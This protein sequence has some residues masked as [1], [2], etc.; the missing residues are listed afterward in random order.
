MATGL[1]KDPA[2][3]YATAGRLAEAAR[4]VLRGEPARGPRPATPTD[5]ADQAGPRPGRPR[6]RAAAR[7]PGPPRTVRPPDPSPAARPGRVIRPDP[8]GRASRRPAPGACRS[9]APRWPPPHWSPARSSGCTRPVRPG[10]RHGRRLAVRCGTSP[11]TCN[12]ADPDELR[13]GGEVTMAVDADVT[14]WNVAA[15]AGLAR[16]DP[17]GDGQRAA[18]HLQLAPD[19]TAHAQHRPADRRRADR[20]DHRRLHDQTGAP[21]G[22]TAPRSASTTSS[23][24]GGCATG[25]TARAASAI[26][27]ATTGSPRSPARPTAGRRQHGDRHVL[28]APTRTGATLFAST[29]PLY[30]AHLAARQ[31]DLRTPTGSAGRLRLVRRHRARLLGRPAGRA[32]LAAGPS[33]GAGPQPA[34]YG[35]PARLD[36]V[37]LQVTAGPGGP[38]AA[39]CATG[40]C[41]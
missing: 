5:R 36:R 20:S 3:R 16:P 15:P 2:E 37:V 4:S 27:P 10:L 40:G 8:I 34:W 17:V 39:R 28:H 23:S 6:P 33:A 26:R 9:A 22:T 35:R 1:A 13:A 21:A 12:G 11:L 29:S 31:G 30:P 32:E 38:G 14:D 18:A 24:T 19:F 41:R 7:P 25:G